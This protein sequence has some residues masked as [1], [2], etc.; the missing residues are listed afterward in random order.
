[1]VTSIFVKEM[2]HPPQ[3]IF[4]LK[5]Q[6]FADDIEDLNNEIQKS[7]NRKPFNFES[8]EVNITKTHN[9]LF[10]PNRLMSLCSYYH[11]FLIK[12]KSS[13][14]LIVNEDQNNLLRGLSDH[15][16]FQ[17]EVRKDL[18]ETSDEKGAVKHK[19]NIYV[20]IET[21]NFKERAIKIMFDWINAHPNRKSKVYIID[22]K[23][24]SADDIFHEVFHETPIGIKYI[25]SLIDLGFKFGLRKFIV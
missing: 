6:L 21:S 23:K 5:G 10:K 12:K 24:M 14:S 3:A 8:F 1:M 13:L 16:E 9:S 11:N 2:K 7:I 25:N 19:S 22:G 20:G 15:F 17:V 4:D 18:S